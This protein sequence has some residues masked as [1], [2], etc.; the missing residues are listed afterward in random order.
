[1][2]DPLAGLWSKADWLSSALLKNCRWRI[3][4]DDLLRFEFAQADHSGTR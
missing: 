3:F 2:S 1:M 4:I